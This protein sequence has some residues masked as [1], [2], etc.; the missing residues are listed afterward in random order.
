MDLPLTETVIVMV[1]V[2]EVAEEVAMDTDL[3]VAALEGIM[4]VE[5]LG[6]TMVTAVGSEA[7][8]AV[9]DVSV[10]TVVALGTLLGTVVAAL[11][12]EAAAAAV[13]VITA[14]GLVI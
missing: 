7:A 12:L 11:E 4:M 2:A 9:E 13:V 3:V 5:V 14:V 6:E 10:T 1:T 8:A